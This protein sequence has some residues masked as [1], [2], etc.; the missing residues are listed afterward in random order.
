M[1]IKLIVL[2]TLLIA[3]CTGRGDLANRRNTALDVAQEAHLQA[4]EIDGGLF[5]LMSWQRIDQPGR[6]A[7]IYIEGD[8]LAWKSKTRP[9]LNPTPGNPIG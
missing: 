5:R 6:T 4:H 7:N 8:G 1:R 2:I 3:G 9:S